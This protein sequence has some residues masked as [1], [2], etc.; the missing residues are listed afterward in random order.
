MLYITY[1][2]PIISWLQT[3]L[4]ILIICSLLLTISLSSYCLVQICEYG[5]FESRF[6]ILCYPNVSTLYLIFEIWG[7][8]YNSYCLIINSLYQIS[9]EKWKFWATETL[10]IQQTIMVFR[11]NLS[12]FLG[13]HVL[14]SLKVHTIICLEHPRQNIHDHKQK[15]IFT[16]SDADVK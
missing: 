6:L 5:F 11:V 14:G 15:L 3:F 13:G 8:F 4:L 7:V 16:P 10:V 1:L 12:L 2:L 9:H